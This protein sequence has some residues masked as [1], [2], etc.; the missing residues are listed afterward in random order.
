MDFEYTNVKNIYENIAI[1]FSDKRYNKWDWIEEFIN[2]N[3]VGSTILDV[4]CGNGR[5]MINNKY[6]FYGIDNCNNFI[7]IANEKKLNVLLSD[8]TNIPFIDN[9][10]DAI[11]SIASF[12]HLS[13]VNRREQCL[14]ELNRIL[15]P[16]GQLLLSVWSINQSH[17][18][19]LNNKFIHGDNIVPW[20]DNKGNIKGNRYYYIFNIEE[21]KTLLEKYFIIKTHFWNHGNEIFIL[22]NKKL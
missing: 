1:E 19:K 4:G 18:R 6:N 12:H 20:K 3:K 22:N 8:M 14:N 16:N 5:N 13:T 11:I 21:I 17:N 15:K 10:F 9:Y 7:N 2:N